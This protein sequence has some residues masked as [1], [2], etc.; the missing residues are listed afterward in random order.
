MKVYNNIFQERKKIPKKDPRNYV[1]KIILNSTYGLSN[2]INSYLYDPLFTMS[3]TL[4]G[5]LLILKLVEMLVLALPE[6][7]IY[8]ENT[9]G[10]SIAYDPVKKDIV[11]KIC[12]EWEK[13]TNLEL[14][15]AFYK[16]MIIMDVNN[17]IAETEDGKLKRKG[18]FE[19]QM[20]FHKNPSFMVIPKA[21]EQYFINNHSVKDYILKHD[22]IYDFL[23]AVKT[24]K[25]FTLNLY[26]IDHS[27]QHNIIINDETLFLKNNGWLEYY[28][29]SWIKQE[30][31]DDKKPYDRMACSKEYA[32][33]SV[34]TS[35]YSSGFIKEKQEKVCRYFISNK[36]GKLIK[37]FKDSR[38][39]RVHAKELQNCLNKIVDE[40]VKS[41]DINYKFYIK[42][43]H[44]IINLIEKPV[45][46]QSSLFNL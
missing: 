27:Y 42:E 32:I 8:Q 10:V 18:L 37:D 46:I 24:T 21:L 40:D 45:G 39:E 36:G 13:L 3:I 31:I 16:Q 35:L 7:V 20:D 15:H 29:D 30:W 1:F 4:N 43:V 17:Y 26:K 9:D 11:D 22:N 12:K 34:K 41:Y 25:D 28:G 33:Q 19:Y 23:G 38:R 14:E 2:E 5:Q 44:K 6:I